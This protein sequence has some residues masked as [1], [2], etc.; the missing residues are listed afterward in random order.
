I[1]ELMIR[2]EPEAADAHYTEVILENLFHV[3]V[4]RTIGKLKEHL[5]DNYRVFMRDGILEIRFNGGSLRYHEPR[6]LR[7][8]YFTDKNGDGQ[9]WRKPIAF[10]F[11]DD[12]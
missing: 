7:A 4:G 9:L 10:D 3:P 5:T 8:P 1:E 11:G 12:L 2:E 6:V